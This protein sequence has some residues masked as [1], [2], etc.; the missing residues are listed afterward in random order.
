[1]SDRHTEDQSNKSQGWRS[2][3]GQ[4]DSSR[5]GKSSWNRSQRRHDNHGTQGRKSGERFWS[6]NDNS[7]KQERT[8]SHRHNN[9]ESYDSGRRYSQR[10]N[11]DRGEKRNRRQQWEDKPNYRGNNDRNAGYGKGR[12]RYNGDERPEGESYGRGS[13]FK[14]GRNQEDREFSARSFRRGGNSGFT[15]NRFNNEE[16]GESRFGGREKTRPSDRFEGT[17]RSQRFERRNRPQR[18]ENN[19]DEAGKFSGSQRFARGERDDKFSRSRR[20]NETRGERNNNRRRDPFV[21]ENVSEKDLN[22]TALR[23]L[24]TLSKENSQRV[25]RHLVYA[26]AVLDENPELAYDHAK[27]A[28]RHAARVDIVREALGITSYMTGRY[29]EAL[30]ELRTYRRMSDDYSHVALEA[31]SER[32][33]GRPEKALAFIADIPLSRLDM[34]TT[35]ELALVTSGARAD[36]GDS[37]S[38]LAVIEKIKS[39]NLPEELR[40]RVELIRADRLEELGRT[41]EAEEIRAKWNPVYTNEGAIDIVEPEVDEAD[42]ATPEADN[43]EPDNAEVEEVG[44]EVAND[45][46]ARDMD[47][48]TESVRE[49][50]NTEDVAE[51]LHDMEESR[52]AEE[53]HDAEVTTAN[54]DCAQ[55][56]DKSVADNSTQEVDEELTKEVDEES[57]TRED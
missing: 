52:D 13:S 20:D 41:E 51:E 2:A 35:L 9:S 4:R 46:E 33:L 24:K 22:A 44:A 36:A 54:D 14:R 34:A 50:E 3:S 48:E 49:A 55:D 25:A 38:G 43:A 31:D 17:E 7:E 8:S 56:E 29:A 57:T 6:R 42:E 45:A 11:N 19:E 32:G 30:R 28:Y 16:R 21:P 5:G 37:Q 39:E 10:D 47:S 23:K 26:G 1:M 12:G 15:R 53:L 27:A 18:F 40:S